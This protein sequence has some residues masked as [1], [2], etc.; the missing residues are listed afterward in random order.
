MWL[1]RKK[2]ISSRIYSDFVLSFSFFFWKIA[3]MSSFEQFLHN[4][5]DS[6]NFF[7]RLCL[8]DEAERKQAVAQLVQ[9]VRRWTFFFFFLL[10]SFSSTSSLLLSMV[11]CAFF[12]NLSLVR[13]NA[14]DEIQLPEVHWCVEKWCFLGGPQ[15]PPVITHMASQ[16]KQK[17]NK[18][19][20]QKQQLQSLGFIISEVVVEWGKSREKGFHGSWLGWLKWF[21]LLLL[22]FFVL[23]FLFR[24][25]KWKRRLKGMKGKKWKEMKCRWSSCERDPIQSFL[26]FHIFSFFI[27]LFWFFWHFL[28]FLTS[29]RFR[30]K[31]KQNKLAGG[32]I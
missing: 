8:R 15:S 9:S 31:T 16:E 26:L 4:C 11:A 2:W 17:Q 6:D 23:L 7:S 28:L 10:S 1:H 24:E 22:S 29:F 27:F 32:Q 19:Q 30:L 3:T 20:K 14:W 21:F 12:C 18:K 13:K 5:G 25:P